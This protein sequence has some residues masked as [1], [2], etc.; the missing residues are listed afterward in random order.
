MQ[1]ENEAG[2]GVGILKETEIDCTF[3]QL[4]FP[5]PPKASDSGYCIAKYIAH[6]KQK[7][8]SGADYANIMFTAVGYCLPTVSGIDYKLT[9][10]WQ[11]GKY[12][13]QLAVSAYDEVIQTTEKGIK[14]YL[15]CGLIKGIG[16][17][18]ADRIY[19][20]FGN[21]TLTILDASPEELLNVQGIQKKTYEKI[22]ASYTANRGAR[23][24]VAL[25]A[26]HGISTRRCVQVFTRF[27]A[28]AV[29]IIQSNPY[30]L[31]DVAGIGFMTADKI[32][33]AIGIGEESPYRISAGIQHTLKEAETGGSL[34]RG[35]NETSG[36]LCLPRATL[37]RKTVELLR[38]TRI[39]EKTVETIVD[40]LI[41]QGKLGFR[42]NQYVFRVYTDK[43]EGLTAKALIEIRNGKI[44]PL[45][46]IEEGI[47]RAQIKLGCKLAPEQQAA[48]IATLE[49]PLTVVTGGPGTG[50]TMIQ[51]VILNVLTEQF[52]EAT[53]VMMAPTGRA[54]RRMSETTGH[55]AT[56]IH[57]ALGL[58]IT[59]D[60]LEMEAHVVEADFIIVDETSMLDIFL[61]ST[62]FNAIMPGTRVLLVG[63]SDQLPSVG[64]GAVLADIIRSNCVP[65]V[66]LLQV[67][68]QSGASLIAINAA[69]MRN[70][71]TEM[72]QGADFQIIPADTF[73]AA[74]NIM[75]DIYID[76]VARVGIDNVVI[77]CPFRKKTESGVD[78]MNKRLQERINP[79][80]PNE[81][82]VTKGDK[83]IRMRDR[84]MITKNT[85]ELANGDIGYVTDVM[86]DDGDITA[87]IDFG[88]H[89]E[90]KCTAE[91]LDKIELS[92]ACTIHKSQG[93]EYRVVIVN[94]MNGHQIMLKRNLLYTSVT[95]AKKKVIIVGQEKAITKAILTEDTSKRLSLLTNRLAFYAKHL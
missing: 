22:M 40:K 56:T 13:L 31:C 36:H 17:K 75:E 53:I 18:M 38:C 6:A 21:N 73:E 82:E 61:A 24:V 84:V 4:I 77:L 1:T 23:D 32:G 16:P 50:K 33:Q 43:C 79:P 15:C 66:K 91:N 68:R 49:N 89:R 46:K 70:A 69:K 86:N 11:K 9:G 58:Q 34:F 78:A 74:A 25:L 48:V 54:A 3:S 7:A 88:E 19:K 62:L 64:P 20:R 35:S 47:K 72:D 28:E 12:G 41:E 14:A 83:I 81:R 10:T 8:E 87:T 39:S 29:S 63:D 65:V 85:D 80:R 42:L 67:Y 37:S 93:S 59:D 95:R 30:K 44:K 60:S 94:I 76:E 55:A 45:E 2:D 92:Y 90:F 71:C 52:P 51:S 57:K 26:P 27:G 5:R